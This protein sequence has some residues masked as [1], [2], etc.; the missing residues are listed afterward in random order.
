MQ[1]RKHCLWNIRKL[2]LFLSELIITPIQAAIQVQTRNIITMNKTKIHMI[3]LLLGKTLPPDLGRHPIRTQC[4]P[5]PTP[6]RTDT[7]GRGRTT[8]E[9]H[10]WTRSTWTPSS[11]RSWGPGRKTTPL[12]PVTMATGK[13]REQGILGTQVQSGRGEGVTTHILV[14]LW[15]VSNNWVCL[16]G[17]LS[18]SSFAVWMC[19]SICM[20]YRETFFIKWSPPHPP[21]LLYDLKFFSAVCKNCRTCMID[22][23]FNFIM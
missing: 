17:L 16:S 2:I 10:S 8:G 19:V 11:Y 5:G 14:F 12:L 3:M 18:L 4:T 6:H 20:C 13:W 1:K 7:A 9:G 15:F 22:I 23:A 21:S